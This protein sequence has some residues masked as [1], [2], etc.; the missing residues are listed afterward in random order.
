MAVGCS[1][2]ATLGSQVLALARHAWP[3]D[4]RLLFC[5]W[6]RGLVNVGSSQLSWAFTTP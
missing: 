6:G 1:T 4:Q 5:F 2:Q 3:V